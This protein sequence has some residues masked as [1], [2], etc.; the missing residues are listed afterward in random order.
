VLI[1]HGLWQR[2]FGGENHVIG[3]TLSLSGEQFT[4]IGVLPAGFGL[5]DPNRELWTP[6]AFSRNEHELRQAHY[7]DAIGRLNPDVTP[8]QAQAEIRTIAA[9]LA[10]QYP[11]TNEGWS[12]TLTPLPQFVVRDVNAVLWILAGA[13]AFVLLIACANVANLLLARTA[14]RRKEIATRAALGAGRLRIVRQLLAESMLLALL[15]SIAGLALAVWGLGALLTLA[16]RDLPR[17]ATVTIDY[18]VLVF[19]L[20][21]T[22]LAGL[23]FGLAPALQLSKPDLNQTLK[24]SRAGS[25]GGESKGRISNL[26]VVGEVALALVLLIGGGLLIRTIWH[27]RHVDPGFDYRQALAVTIQLSEKKYADQQTVAR[28]SQ[29]LLQRVTALPGVEAAGVARILPIIHDLPAAFYLEGQPHDQVN[30][31][32]Q[33]NYS[34]VSP[35]YFKAMGIPLLEGRGF[36]GRDTAGATRV[37]IISKTMADRFFPNQEAIGKRLNVITGPEA[38]REIVGIVGDVK[39]NGLDREVRPHIYE[40]FAQAP[41]QFMTLVVRTTSAPSTLVA[42]IRGQVLE[43]D[44]EQPLQ[45]FRTLDEVIS[46]SIR[47]QRFIALLLSIFAVAA[48]LLAVAGLYGVISYSVTQRTHELGIRVALGAQVRDV[49]VLVIGK[50]MKLTLTGLAIGLIS[51]W[52]LSRLMSNLLFGVGPTDLPTFALIALGMLGVAL[53]ACYIPARRAAKVDPLVALRYE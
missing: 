48:L 20:G 13:V 53:L 7:I 6:I 39:Q 12:V 4:V 16:P 34:A 21:I 42:A 25:A 10:Q 52:Q 47:Q 11:A 28:F 40:P 29:Q 49:L 32:P 2:R 44:G 26:L 38:Y 37:A 14:T 17:A 51:A 5:P 46:Y 15:G 22:L 19:T 9:R 41:N 27:L 33:T 30:Q 23:I 8:D 50:G 1:S 3:R 45:S 35:D 24:D 36:A 31:L 18:R 43:I